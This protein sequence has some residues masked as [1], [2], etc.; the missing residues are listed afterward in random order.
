MET[1]YYGV[2]ICDTHLG[3]IGVDVNVTVVLALQVLKTFEAAEEDVQAKAEEL[4][5]IANKYEKAK[6]LEDKI[7]GVEVDISLQLQ[8]YTKVCR[9]AFVAGNDT[10]N[11][12]NTPIVVSRVPVCRCRGVCGVGAPPE[13]GVSRRGSVVSRFMLR[14]VI[15]SFRQPHRRV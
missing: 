3:G 7:K 14:A 2:L 13:Y 9:W 1:G 11:K 12:N 10:K 15:C 8:E 4:H 5:E 6:A